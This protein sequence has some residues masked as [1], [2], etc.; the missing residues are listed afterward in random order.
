MYV[1]AVRDLLLNEKEVADPPKDAQ[2]LPHKTYETRF[3]QKTGA[4]KREM[5]SRS[6]SAGAEMIVLESPLLAG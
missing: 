1:T 3:C 6:Q 5:N 4:P 2:T